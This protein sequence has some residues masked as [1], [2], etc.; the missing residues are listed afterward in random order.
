V[1]GRG[2][3][4]SEP[5]DVV[6]V[7]ELMGHAAVNTTRRYTLPTEVDKTRALDALTTDR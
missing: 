3:L 6:L 5:V 2:E 1:R 7:A 4:A